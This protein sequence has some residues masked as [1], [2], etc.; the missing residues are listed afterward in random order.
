[1]SVS[2]GSVD[3][4]LNSAF[5]TDVLV[6]LTICLLFLLFNGFS[7]LL[8]HTPRLEQNGPDSDESPGVIITGD[9][10]TLFGSVDIV[11]RCICGRGLE[12]LSMVSFSVL[13][14]SIILV[15][16]EF[17]V[18]LRVGYGP[19]RHSEMMALILLTSDSLSNYNCFECNRMLRYR[20]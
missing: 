13:I 4:V 20:L 15:A 14:L 7:I 12:V 1:M 9:I 16:C 19:V 3:W 8:Q 2:L 11:V 6:G 17:E 5:L 10:L 18:I